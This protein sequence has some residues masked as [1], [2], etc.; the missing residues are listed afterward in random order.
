M[1]KIKNILVSK[2]PIFIFFLST[3]IVSIS[4]F[5]SYSHNAILSYGDAEAHINISKRVIDSLTPGVAQL[6]GVWLPLPHI[7]MIP[8]VTNDFLWRTGLAGSIVSGIA[9]MWLAYILYKFAYLVTNNYYASFIAPLVLLTNLNALY[10]ATTPMSEI[11][12]LSSLSSAMY[13]FIK[14]V[15]DKN[16]MFLIIAGFFTFI[17]SLI[18]YD[19]WMLAVVL[20]AAVAFITLLRTQSFS[21]VQGKVII[22]GFVSFL[23]IGLWLAWNKLIFSN[24]LYFA[25]SIYGS[26]AQQMWFYDRGY[27]PTYNNLPLSMLYYAT[28][29]A[30]ILGIIVTVLMIVGALIYLFNLYKS[31]D[32]LYSLSLLLLFFSFLFYSVS[33][34]TG[35]ASIILPMFSESWYQWDMSNVRYGVQMVLPAAIFIS[36][37][38][39]KL[40]RFGVLVAALVILQG[41]YFIKTGDVLTY[42]DATRGLSSQAISKGPDAIPVEKWIV[43]HYDGGLVLMDDYRRPISP[44]TSGIPM[45]KFI[46]VGNKPYWENGMK[47]PAKVANWV[48]L[49]KATT[50][51]VW[52]RINRNIL[53]G[54]YTV[55]FKSGNIWV[56]KIRKSKGDFVERFGSDLILHDNKFTF[57]AANIYDLLALPNSD[58]TKLLDFAIQE[59]IKVIRFWGFNKKGTLTSGDFQEFDQVLSETAKRNLRLSVV[60]VNQWSDWGGIDNYFHGKNNELF[61]SN[62]VNK[63]EFKNYISTIINRTSLLDSVKYKDNPTILNWEL[64]NEPRIEKDLSGTTLV[65]WTRE[66]SEFIR[67]IDQNHLVSIGTEGFLKDKTGI[68]YY[69]D[70]G[71]YLNDICAIPSIDICSAHFFPKYIQGE[72]NYSNIDAV[73]AMWKSVAEKVNK[74]LYIGEIGYD[75][76]QGT[77]QKREQF[78]SDIKK[79]LSSKQV[80][81]GAVWGMTIEPNES[82]NISITDK[83]D[84]AILENWGY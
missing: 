75:L 68:S 9:F 64:V 74:P 11:L 38:T 57:N 51:S 33:L 39:H 48:I 79:S 5:W 58:R 70:H 71:A 82:Y 16:V 56:Y 80:S 46:G 69:E 40:G 50:D 7:L 47:N 22:F 73:I 13:F 10:L 34:F 72:L 45:S 37:L 17:A 53:D 42:I 3:I 4:T 24:F 15:K 62:E 84:Q 19:G 83:N 65:T 63:E 52:N 32:K 23:G 35:Q 36:Y 54:Y 25:N 14:W 1:N 21:K 12:L 30:I 61:Y 43:S 67:S 41:L 31:K 59:N 2:L 77:I 55:A 27:L 28:G 26:K 81:G 76:E 20:I 49:Q 66:M 78:F 44:I 6:G 18:R 60:F 8:L 29:S